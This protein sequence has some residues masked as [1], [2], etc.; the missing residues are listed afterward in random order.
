MN[1]VCLSVNVT[2]G[3]MVG[4]LWVLYDFFFSAIYYSPD[5]IDKNDLKDDTMNRRPSF[6]GNMSREWSN[7]ERI[8]FWRGLVTKSR[9]L[10]EAKKRCRSLIFFV[11]RSVKSVL[12]KKK[13]STTPALFRCF[14]FLCLHEWMFY[15]Y[16]VWWKEFSCLKGIQPTK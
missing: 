8:L 1:A 15:L 14:S 9:K 12:P 7:Q 10:K 2:I 5:Q 4:C 6:C 3:Q 16:I 13:Q 11:A